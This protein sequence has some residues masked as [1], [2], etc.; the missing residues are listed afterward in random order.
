MSARS[1]LITGRWITLIKSSYFNPI[2]GL[3]FEHTISFL[4]YLQA[5]RPA[6]RI[7]VIGDGAFYHR[8]QEVKDYLQ[9]LNTLR[10]QHS[11]QLTC[12]RFAPNAPEQNPAL[13]YLV[14]GEAIF[15]RVLP[16]V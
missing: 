3:T 14:T 2:L 1:K 13:R 8:S 15:K 11:W 9:S 7:A 10:E 4:S 16:P 6:Q 5:Q 12:I